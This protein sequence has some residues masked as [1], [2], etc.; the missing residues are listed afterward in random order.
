MTDL[1]RLL[2]GVEPIVAAAAAKLVAMQHGPLRTERKDLLDVV[3]EADLASR[4]SW[5]RGC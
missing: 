1:I 3:T 5:S 2:E 4:R